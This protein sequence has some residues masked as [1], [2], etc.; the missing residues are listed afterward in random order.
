ME[1]RQ[2]PARCRKP[3]PKAKSRLTAAFAVIALAMTLACGSDKET[4]RYWNFGA[5][6]WPYADTLSLAVDTAVTADIAVVVRHTADYEYSDLWVELTCATDSGPA[7]ADTF[8]IVLAD[9]FGRW[10]GHGVGV[11]LQYAD[12]LMRSATLGDSS[13]VSVR[14]IMR[15]D[16][17]PGIEQVG[18][19]LNYKP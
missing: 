5:E 16:T 14:H 12:T 11:G 13:L 17:L 15:A 2:F 6:G 7:R 1:Q 19:V 4:S 9:D 10:Q 18:I 3:G 8:R